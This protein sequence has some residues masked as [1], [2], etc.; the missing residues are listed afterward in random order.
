ML[1]ALT[2]LNVHSTKSLTRLKKQKFNQSDWPTNSVFDNCTLPNPVLSSHPVFFHPLF[3]L[4]PF[5]LTPRP[6]TCE[7][8]SFTPHQCVRACVWKLSQKSLCLLYLYLLL[9]HKHERLFSCSGSHVLFS[10]HWT[11]SSGCDILCMLFIWTL[12]NILNVN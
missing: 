3:V 2:L 5:T 8:T 12:F 10:Q 6:L 9:L 1:L 4:S 7:A 11:N